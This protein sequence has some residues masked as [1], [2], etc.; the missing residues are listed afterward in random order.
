MCSRKECLLF[1]IIWLLGS[2]VFHALVF[3]APPDE[4]AVDF[5][6]ATMVESVAPTPNPSPYDCP[7]CK[8][9]GWIMHG[10]GHQTKCP[11]CDLA[12]LPGG[13]FDIIRQAKELI[14]RGN[15]LAE[16]GKAL[17]DAFEKDGKATIDVRLPSTLKQPEIIK[18]AKPV[19]VSGGCANGQCGITRNKYTPIQ[20]K[21]NWRWKR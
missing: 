3:G 11:N 10:D 6:T 4:V 7:T 14:R 18:S 8:D 19:V 5:A 9:T 13:P 20:K 16:R 15:E 1:I 2:F 12:G 21:N 17:L